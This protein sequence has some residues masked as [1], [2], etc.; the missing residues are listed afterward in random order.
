ME[1]ETYIVGAGSIGGHIVSNLNLYN[2][3]SSKINFV[4]DDIEKLNTHHCGVKVAGNIDTLLQTLKE[5]DVIVAIANPIVKSDI[6][7]KLKKN[8]N[9]RF[10]SLIAN[11]SWFSQGVSLGEGC[12]IYPNCSINYGSTLGDFVLLN[13]NCTI[14]HHNSIATCSSLYPSVS[15]GGNTKILENVEIGIGSSIIQHITIGKNAII[16]AGSVVIN[17]VIDNSSVVGVPA[18]ELRKEKIKE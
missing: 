13:M 2:L 15:T 18:K 7:M 9:I 10:P 4:D 1:R 6:V 11:N 3:I 8:N 16:G 5:I 14:G 17:D 12:I